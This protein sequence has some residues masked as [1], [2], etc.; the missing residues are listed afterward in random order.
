MSMND[1]GA[2]M[3]KL[4]V[5]VV[6][7][8]AAGLTLLVIVHR[9]RLVRLP[10]ALV[11]G[12]WYAVVAMAFSWLGFHVVYLLS[13][14][15]RDSGLAAIARILAFVPIYVCALIVLFMYPKKQLSA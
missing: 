14:N 4:N 15:P 11:L 3:S 6:Y 2:L 5:F 8:L 10:R 13:H 9:V 12:C 1:I 7:G